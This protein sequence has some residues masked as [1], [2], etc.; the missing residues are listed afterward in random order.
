MHGDVHRSSIPGPSPA[1]G[2]RDGTSDFSR[3][4]ESD[5]LLV[6]TRNRHVFRVVDSH[7]ILAEVNRFSGV[8][9]RDDRSNR[10]VCVPL[11]DKEIG[12]QAWLVTSSQGTF[13]RQA[14]EIDKRVDQSDLFDRTE[15][16]RV[17][18]RILQI[19]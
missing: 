15:R 11:Q 10:C 9:T 4:L 2:T 16:Q 19:A 3:L 1:H 5:D 14:D 18:K 6:R 12:T 8:R 7:L 17:K 13:A